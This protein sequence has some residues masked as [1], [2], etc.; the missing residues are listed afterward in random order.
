M[1]TINN[2]V[3]QKNVTNVRLFVLFV[4]V[5][6]S[7]TGVFAQSSTTEV[8]STTAT[9]VSV[10]KEATTVIA[11][12]NGIATMDVASWIMGENN[13]NTVKTNSTNFGK[14]QLI[15]AGITT[16]SVLVR[17]LLKKVVYQASSVA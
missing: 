4:L 14:K 9:Q 2:T 12:E 17:T 15:N 7:S 11:V 6:L 3:A 13:N 8:L 1:T 10:S 5:L 16:N